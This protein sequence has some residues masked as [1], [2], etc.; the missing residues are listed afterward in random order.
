MNAGSASDTALL[1]TIPEF[2]A[3]ASLLKATPAEEAGDRML[4][5]EAS[6]EDPDYQNEVVLA[7]ALE[8]SA[9]YYLRHGNVD[10]SHY[11]VLGPRSGLSNFLE[12][13]IGRP[14]DVRADGTRTF[15]KAQLYRG[16]SPQAKNAGM[17]W[18]SLT[19]Q[20]P[21]QRWYPSVGGQVLSK[22][23]RIDPQT[24]AKVAVVDKVRWTN[25][26]LDRCPVNTIVGTASTVPLGVFAKSMGAFVMAKTLEAG[27]GTDS[28]TLVGGAALRKQSL[29]GSMANYWEFRDRL[30]DD[31]RSLRAGANP[32]AK[33]LVAHATTQ[34]GLPDDGAAEMVERFMRDLKSHLHRGART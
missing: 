9:G 29:H 14:V 23:V 25:T 30:A 31:V 32:G 2:I 6:T 4:Y 5:L 7:K 15:V 22:S 27:Y 11:T 3:F 26:A 34:Y 24:G 21:P 12:Y 1:G 18:E 8:E 19:R 13:E 33:D 20:D 10:I 28:A 17:V 16:D